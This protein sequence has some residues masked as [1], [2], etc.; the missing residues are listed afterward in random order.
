MIMR[1]ETLKSML[2][3]NTHLYSVL[4]QWFSDSQIRRKIHGLIAPRRRF[5]ISLRFAIYMYGK[6]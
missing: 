4:C 5:P 1:Q 3:N 2:Q 6:R